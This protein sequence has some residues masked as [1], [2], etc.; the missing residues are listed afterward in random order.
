MDNSHYLHVQVHVS[1]ESAR[2]TLTAG[3]GTDFVLPEKP[4]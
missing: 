1:S 4:S 3:T 2:D